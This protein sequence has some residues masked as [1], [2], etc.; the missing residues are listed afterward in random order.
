MDGLEIGDELTTTCLLNNT[1][2]G[3]LDLNLDLDDK[4]EV[5]TAYMRDMA[6]LS[7]FVYRACRY[8]P[9]LFT[10]WWRENSS[11]ADLSGMR[12]VGSDATRNARGANINGSAHTRNHRRRHSCA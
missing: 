3:D 1:E 10:P 8:L 12:V 2:E 11:E 4:D 9:V 5:G 6:V 7:F